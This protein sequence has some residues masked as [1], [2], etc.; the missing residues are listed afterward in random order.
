MGKKMA[1]EPLAR[2]LCHDNFIRVHEND[3]AASLAGQFLE[4][5]QN[6]A[7][8]F[9]EN[10]D[11]LG[12]LTKEAFLKKHV[13]F[14]NL[15]LKSILKGKPVLY[16]DEPLSKIAELFFS[17]ETRML[18]VFEKHQ[19]VGV[20]TTQDILFQLEKD[21]ALE[22]IPV[23]Q[24]ANKNPVLLSENATTEKA[25]A[26]MRD[27]K[28][29]RLPLVS[30][31]GELTGLFSFSDALQN[32]ALHEHIRPRG[33]ALAGKEHPES[34]KVLDS[35][36]KEFSS[37]EPKTIR[38]N[39]SLTLAL[40]KMREKN[41]SSL[42]LVENNHPIGILTVRDV[43][44]L[45]LEKNQPV[46]NVQFSNK[47]AL[48]EIDS[49]ILDKKIENFL[50]K[51]SRKYSSEIALQIH[52]KP[53]KGNGK[54]RKQ[55]FVKMHIRGPGINLTAKIWNWKF[56]LAIQEGLKTLEIEAEKKQRKQ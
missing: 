6:Q 55:H 20:V 49:A 31:N 43:L 19:M 24:V 42:V 16:G 40:Q 26:V 17:S 18:P 25:L 30:S 4:K 48:D 23:K 53:A 37:S 50:D 45:L 35:P 39:D 51:F 10:N 47:P 41:L 54:A 27:K 13:D 34:R 14:S 11:Y 28:I 21:P 32:L 8:V 2:E 36:V 1:R 29:N 12:V 9:S 44:K 38:P 5:K 46:S 3:S 56:L 22:K 7:L 33:S 52:C 15:K